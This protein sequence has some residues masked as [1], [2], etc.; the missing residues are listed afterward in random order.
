L[1]TAPALAFDAPVQGSGKTLLARCVGYLA[2][3]REPDLF[4]HT[5]S[6]DDEEPRKRLFATLVMGAT[7]LIWDNVT[8]SF[9]S[10][11]MAGFL[12]APVIADRVLGKSQALRLPNRVLLLF[13]GNNLTFE[14]DMPRRVIKCRIDPHSATPFA[15]EFAMDPLAYVRDYRLDMVT[16]ACT[17]IRA[18][19]TSGAKCAKGRMASFEDWD[20]IVRQTVVWVGTVLAP[21]EYGDP[22]DLVREAQAADPSIDALGDLLQ[23]LSDRFGADWFTGTDVQMACSAD[24]SSRIKE[25]LS[26]VAGV[27][28]SG[29]ARRIGK[30]LSARKGQIAHDLRLTARRLNDKD[31]VSYRVEE[32]G[33]P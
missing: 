33:D 12:T 18:Y 17:L 32:A 31:A 23:V 6:R 27:D 28:V 20:D 24:P 21:G 10:A 25:A 14:G 8:G 4:S 7:T 1:L 2:N 15:R 3:G 19:Q 30:L 22:M 5:K 16:A 11:A 26:D 29:S 9:D 13:T